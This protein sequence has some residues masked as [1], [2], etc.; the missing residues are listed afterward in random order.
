VARPGST[1]REPDPPFGL[2]EEPSGRQGALSGSRR[3]PDGL[4]RSLARPRFDG[5]NYIE[6]IGRACAIVCA[7]PARPRRGQNATVRDLV[8]NGLA[9]ARIVTRHFCITVGV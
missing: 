6:V 8:A 4:R 5:T 3:V 7:R 1:R 9:R 2:I